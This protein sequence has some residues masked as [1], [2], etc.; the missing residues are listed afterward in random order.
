[1]LFT[2]YKVEIE[3]LFNTAKDISFHQ[4]IIDQLKTH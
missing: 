1:M 3:S 4:Y 2:N